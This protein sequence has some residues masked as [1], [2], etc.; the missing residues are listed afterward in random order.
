[1]TVTADAHALPA[2]LNACPPGDCVP[3][4]TGCDPDQECNPVAPPDAGFMWFDITRK[5]QLNCVHCYN[6]SGPTG[7]HG[8]MSRAHWFSL[9][10]EAVRSG[11]RGIQIIGG[12]P[13]MHPD[14]AE[15]VTHARKIGL[16][17]EVFSNLVTIRDD[18]WD[19]FKRESVTLATSYYSDRSAEHNAITKRKSHSRTR[20]NIQRAAE[21]GIPLRVGIIAADDSQRV[22]EA[23][24]EVEALGATSVCV[25][26]VREFGRGANGQEPDTANLCGRCGVG[27]A[28]IGPDGTVSPCVFSTWLRVGNVQEE[29]LAAILSGAAMAEA[30]A[31]IQK[32]A[33]RGKG[34]CAPNTECTPGTPPT[35]CSPRN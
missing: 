22:E 2:V 6:E 10:D 19:M 25:D 16:A 8:T 32:T 23:R 14:F 7:T 29:G 35:S 3:D 28:S 26:R 1:M 34:D 17:V 33:V 13:T 31:T 30:V 18:W 4:G 12:E 15:L 5:C 9:M 27:R 20:A 24:R 11:T 21:S